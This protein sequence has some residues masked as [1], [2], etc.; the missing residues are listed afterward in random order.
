MLGNRSLESR[1]LQPLTTRVRATTY[2]SCV[3][4]RFF[5]DVSS[6]GAHIH[7]AGGAVAVRVLIMSIGYRYQSIPSGRLLAARHWCVIGS[8]GNT[9]FSADLRAKLPRTQEGST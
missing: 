6:A 2:M 9:R 1:R 8:D 4:L 5:L 3:S 7:E